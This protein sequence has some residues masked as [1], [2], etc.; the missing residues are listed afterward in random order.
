[1]S[2]NLSAIVLSHQIPVKGYLW[3]SKSDMNI[4]K[5]MCNELSKYIATNKDDNIH[6]IHDIK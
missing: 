6:K 1:M 4:E 3:K 2:I 5:Y